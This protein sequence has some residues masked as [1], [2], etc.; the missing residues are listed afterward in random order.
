[1]IILCGKGGAGKDTVSWI[2]QNVYGI[3]RVVTYTTRPKRPGE[4]DG[5]DY[6]FISE[7][8]FLEKESA[9]FFAE[10]SETG[11]NKYGSP[12]DAYNEICSQIILDPNGLRQALD[13]LD[14]H[15][16][17]VFFLDADDGLLRK[18]M[19]ARGDAPEKVE[20]RL[21]EDAVR[22]NGVDSLCDITIRQTSA[23]EAAKIA[24]F[25]AG[26]AEKF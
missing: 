23:T 2:L 17:N 4:K 24:C 11:R 26:F 9:G 16:L 12:A 6:H 5:F 20:E 18:R 3:P 22:F 14:R 7:E 15:S 19:L 21:A 10:T 25:I 13:R 1:M 8:E